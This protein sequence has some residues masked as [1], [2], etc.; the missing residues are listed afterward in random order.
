MIKVGCTAGI[1][2]GGARSIVAGAIHIQL[3]RSAIGCGWEAGGDM[4]PVA[5]GQA[6]GGTGDGG[7]AQIQHRRSRGVQREF[8]EGTGADWLRIAEGLVCR[9]GLKPQGNGTTACH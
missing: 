2:G 3:G 5:I 1:D 9:G 4:V 8:E 7:T 6:G